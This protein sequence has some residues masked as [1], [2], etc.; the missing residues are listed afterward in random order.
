M[1]QSIPSK[2]AHL[3]EEQTSDSEE[4]TEVLTQPES[5]EQSPENKVEECVDNI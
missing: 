1:G 3:F 2:D 5:S 4:S